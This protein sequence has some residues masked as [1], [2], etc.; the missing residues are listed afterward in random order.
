MRWGEHRK[1][2]D[3]ASK[4]ELA[5]RRIPSDKRR[6][7]ARSLTRQPEMGWQGMANAFLVSAGTSSPGAM[8]T[9]CITQVRAKPNIIADNVKPSLLF[10]AGVPG[11]RQT[12]ARFVKTNRAVPKSMSRRG[13]R[14]AD[15]D[16]TVLA[17]FLS[18][19]LRQ[20]DEEA[21]CRDVKRF[22]VLKLLLVRPTPTCPYDVGQFRASR[23]PP[24][25]PD[26]GVGRR[27]G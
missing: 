3:N 17:V 9:N 15:A 7:T 6:R 12:N 25:R 11:V 4:L 24:T 19:V 21:P 13:R 5:N 16:A 26:E 22:S 27:L 1:R 2:E 8:R 20:R 10:F 23:T 14:S 18:D